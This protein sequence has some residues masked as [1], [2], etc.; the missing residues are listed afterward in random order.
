V[1]GYQDGPPQ[2]LPEVFGH[3]DGLD[4]QISFALATTVIDSFLFRNPV[5]FPHI[6]HSVDA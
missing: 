4:A 5:V 2:P 1:L 6:T 3:L